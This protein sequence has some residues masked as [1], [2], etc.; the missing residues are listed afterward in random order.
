MAQR[1][2]IAAGNW[3]M[4]P[5][6]LDEA[7]ELAEDLAT[8]LGALAGTDMVL[9]PPLPFISPVADRL[10]GTAIAVGVQNL[11]WEPKGAFTGEVAVSMLPERVGWTLIGHSERRQYFC[12]SDETVNKKLRAVLGTLR[13]IVCVGESLAERDA[14]QV[15]AVLERQVRGALEGVE[16]G[17]EF[18][19]DSALQLAYEPVWAIG[20]GRAATPE[21]ANQA[22]GF[23]RRV[24]ATLRGEEFARRLR[25]LYGGSVTD[26]NVA[27]IM[28]QPEI[29]GALVGG[30]SLNAGA[31][32]AIAR[33]IAAARAG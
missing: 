15:E 11:H 18:N 30:A 32:A 10:D 9:F 6:T 33:A 24:L 21:Q 17:A 12:E 5:P 3:K 26:K 4:N 2:P 23:I 7:V 1:R 16:L 25:I 14:G 31:F 20:T 13:P 22:M 8:P 28:A 19:P 27:E 29:D